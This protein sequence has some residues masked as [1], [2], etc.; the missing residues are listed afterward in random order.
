MMRSLRFAACGLLLGV[1]LPAAAY[2]GGLC[3]LQLSSLAGMASDASIAARDLDTA[4]D[5]LR[6]CS[7]NCSRENSQMESA[8]RWF[9]TV[10]LNLSSSIREAERLCALGPVPGLPTMPGQTLPGE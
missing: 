5:K 6:R 3:A 1:G 2:Q 7:S 8:A 4:R 10:S 9:A